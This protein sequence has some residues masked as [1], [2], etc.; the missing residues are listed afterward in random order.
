MHFCLVEALFVLLLKLLKITLTLV[1]SSM[2]GVP[3]GRLQVFP[4]Q[5]IIYDRGFSTLSNR[6]I[7][8][9]LRLINILKHI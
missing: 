2:L 6:L 1:I 7:G 5:P 3:I 4:K 8:G 9:L